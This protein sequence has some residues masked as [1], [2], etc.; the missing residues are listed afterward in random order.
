[1]VKQG[2]EVAVKEPTATGVQVY[3]PFGGVRALGKGVICPPEEFVSLVW[4][5]GVMEAAKIVVDKESGEVSQEKV[6]FRGFFFDMS[7]PELN[8]AAR[9]AKLDELLL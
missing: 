7:D 1:M 4:F 5:T 2:Q 8:R 6:D 9:A 3:N